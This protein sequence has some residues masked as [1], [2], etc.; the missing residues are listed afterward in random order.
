MTKDQF[1]EIAHQHQVQV[2]Q[3]ILYLLG[4]REDAKDITQST[5]RQKIGESF[6]KTVK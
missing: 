6:M 3:H 2:Y 1:L 5:A 4:N